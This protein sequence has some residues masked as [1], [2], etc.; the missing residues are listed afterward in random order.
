M[1]PAKHYPYLFF[2]G[3]HH[4]LVAYCT[5]QPYQCW[6]LPWSHSGYLFS[7]GWLPANGN[8]PRRTYIRF[9]QPSCRVLLDFLFSSWGWH[10]YYPNSI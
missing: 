1:F 2:V 6:Q 7:T 10:W 8:Q 5:R 3:H 9:A 4:N